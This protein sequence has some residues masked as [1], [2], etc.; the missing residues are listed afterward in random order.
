MKK[1]IYAVI[2]TLLH[3]LTFSQNVT[4]ISGSEKIKWLEL[5]FNLVGADNQGFYTIDCSLDMLNNFTLTKYSS[6]DMNKIYSQKIQTPSVNNKKCQA[7]KI[8]LLDNVLVL[9]TT[10]YDGT[11][12]LHKL[13]ANKFNPDGSLNP[14]SK[15]IAEIKTIDKKTKGFFK[16]S[17]SESKKTI[18]VLAERPSNET[19]RISYDWKVIDKDLNTLWDKSINLPY[20]GIDSDLIVKM[21]YKNDKIYFIATNLKDISNKDRKNA[22]AEN[23]LYCYDL[24]TSK[25]TD[26]VLNVTTKSLFDLNINFNDKNQVIL[27]GLYTFSNLLDKQVFF[28]KTNMLRKVNGAF[29][30]IYSENLIETIYEDSIE[31]I[32][33]GYLHYIN[34]VHIQKDGTIILIS[35]NREYKEGASTDHFSRDAFIFA[36]NSINKAKWSKRIKKTQHDVGENELFSTISLSNNNN[37]LAL[38]V[39]DNKE[40]IVEKNGD[41]L[42]FQNFTLKKN[43]KTNIINLDTKGNSLVQ[44]FSNSED[45]LYCGVKCRISPN[46]MIIALKTNNGN[47]YGKITLK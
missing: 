15:L 39:N 38:L 33:E 27:T 14:D 23:K 20:Y 41:N 13:Y 2:I 36:F 1:T 5:N 34:D 35:E 11:D 7:K 44:E 6:A 22:I 4:L 26:I 43:A 9:F 21:E 18:L 25:L 10:L 17:L 24:K 47:V 16:L 46:E 19:D 12:D 29:C 40:N 32:V 28:N 42:T 3:F 45:V 31:S 37:N 8:L 30:S